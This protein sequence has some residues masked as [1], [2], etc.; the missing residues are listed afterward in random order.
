MCLPVVNIVAASSAFGL[1]RKGGQGGNVLFLRFV[2][3]GVYIKRF[4]D[5][6]SL[7]Y[8]DTQNDITTAG[9]VRPPY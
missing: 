7:K 4:T 5:K 6:E 9:L 1:L 3:L 2:C 8:L